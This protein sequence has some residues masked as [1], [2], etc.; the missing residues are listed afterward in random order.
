MRIRP[1]I[2]R[3]KMDKQKIRKLLKIF[4]PDQTKVD[5][6]KFDDEF[7]KLK[8][9]L[10]QKV[11]AQTLDDVNEKL[12]KSRQEISGQLDKLDFQPLL[13][14]FD[15]LKLD[16][17]DHSHQ[18]VGTLDEKYE[19]LTEALKEALAETASQGSESLKEEISRLEAEIK[20]LSARKIE[21]PDFAKQIKDTELK[22]LE[23]VRTS[24]T[25]E[26]LK[27][28]K[29][30]EGIQAQF[31][32]FEL[33]LKKLRLDFQHRGGGSMNRN[34]AIGGNTSVLAKYTDINI[35]AGSNVTLTYSNNNNTKY[36]D[37]TI[38]ATGG[39]GS[40]GGTVRSIQTLTASS[41]IGTLSGTDQVYLANG[42]I[43]ITLPTAVSD[44]NLYTIKNVGTSSVL[45]NTTSAQT[46][47]GQATIVM[48]VQYT[49]VDIVSDNT[50][51]N[52]T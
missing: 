15:T 23:V 40:V 36:L 16:L 8:D 19:E 14:A 7:Q 27:E 42:G 44:T 50:N 41:T 13:E 17:E 25:M 26:E 22:L 3:K 37:L 2:T 31:A 10:K 9:S 21:I 32:A 6:G 45:I 28:E 46:I 1:K 51:W 43:Q 4:T 30:N 20:V 47:D 49:S 33:A 12:D 38:S 29:N 48:P 35:K 39:S 34:I 5:F 18:L 11:H 52:V 24:Q